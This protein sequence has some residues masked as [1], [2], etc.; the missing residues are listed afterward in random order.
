MPTMTHFD[1]KSAAALATRQTRICDTSKNTTELPRD[2]L[3]VKAAHW[4]TLS[5]HL[6]AVCRARVQP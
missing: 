1:A 2:P 5:R 6:A 3:V 4:A